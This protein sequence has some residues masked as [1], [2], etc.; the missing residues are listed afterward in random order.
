MK[1][2]PPPN[3]FGNFAASLR[4]FPG[5]LADTDMGFYIL[6][7]NSMVRY[8]AGGIVHRP[9]GGTADSQQR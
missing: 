2:K 3:D 5:L 8:S 1:I 7:R 9:G 6:D 4:E